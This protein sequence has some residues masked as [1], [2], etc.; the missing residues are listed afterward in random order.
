MTAGKPHHFLTVRVRPAE[1]DH[2]QH[3]QVVVAHSL[4]D[5]VGHML[6]V[7]IRV[8][9]SLLVDTQVEGTPLVEVHS[10]MEVGGC[11]PEL[12]IHH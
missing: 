7:D 10:W 5:A 11:S 8:V 4:R 1:V 9:D 6:A 2:I 12:D 3:S